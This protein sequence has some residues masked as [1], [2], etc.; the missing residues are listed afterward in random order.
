MGVLNV[1]LS[2]S[3]CPIGAELFWLYWST[4]QWYLSLSVKQMLLLWAAMM[5]RQGCYGKLQG[6]YWHKFRWELMG[7]LNVR[8]SDSVFE[9]KC[10]TGAFIMGSCDDEVGVLQEIMGFDWAI[11]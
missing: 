9:F 4:I 3:I 6:C 2:N 5:T 7:V 11:M 1:R 8:L 10:E